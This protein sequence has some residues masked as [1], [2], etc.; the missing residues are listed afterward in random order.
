VGEWLLKGIYYHLIP[1]FC[2]VSAN[3]ALASKLAT[4]ISNEINDLA[5]VLQ[6]DK[7]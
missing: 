7:A 4:K 3:A 6:A 1:L 2:T 5:P